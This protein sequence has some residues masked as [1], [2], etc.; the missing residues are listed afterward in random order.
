MKRRVLRESL[1]R[2]VVGSADADSTN[3]HCISEGKIN[4][5]LSIHV[6]AKEQRVIADEEI[7]ERVRGE[8]IEAEGGLGV[9]RTKQILDAAAC[10]G[11]GG[12]H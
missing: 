2:T 11:N 4:E 1:D 8:L 9:D 12:R 5:Q 6:A 10:S 3:L 7:A